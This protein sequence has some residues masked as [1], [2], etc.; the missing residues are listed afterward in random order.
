MPK[1]LSLSTCMLVQHAGH[2][3]TRGC[4]P[5]PHGWDA[6]HETPPPFKKECLWAAL[7]DRPEMHCP[8]WE[9][10]ALDGEVRMTVPASAAV[11]V[12]EN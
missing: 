1:V 11:L 6:S 7:P 3:A 2:H 9:G 4:G 8:L 10:F 5:G 12:N